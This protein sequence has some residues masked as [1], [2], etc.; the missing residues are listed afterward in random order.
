MCSLICRP[1]V[2]V[3]NEAIM[4]KLSLMR[5][6]FVRMEERETLATTGA[7]GSGSHN[8]PSTAAHADAPA[9]T[10]TL[11]HTASSPPAQVKLPENKT[12]VTI[13]GIRA[14]MGLSDNDRRWREVQVSTLD[15]FYCCC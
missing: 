10:N 4:A 11:A 6:M 5:A 14:D 3:S 1:L 13:A 8:R 7:S 9:R 2:I 15:Y 12:N